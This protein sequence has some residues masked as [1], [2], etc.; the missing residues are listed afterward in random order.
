LELDKTP[1]AALL[2]AA[3]GQGILARQLP[4]HVHYAGVDIAEQLI[5]SAKQRTKRAQTQFKVGDIT[6]ALPFPPGTF[7]HASCILALQN[8]QHGDQAVRQIAQALKPG[9]RCVF[10]LNH[11]CFRI[12]RQSHWAVDEG[13]SLQYRRV[14]RYM[15]ALDIPIQTNPSQGKKSQETWSFHHPLSSY[16]QWLSQAGLSLTAMEEWCSDKQSSG[17]SAKRENRAR[18]EIPLFLA[19]AATKN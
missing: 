6:Q 16:I 13:Q 10:V 12:P 4:K 7:S 2:D 3:C 15:S 18:Q 5:Q 8:I 11:P 9:G 19:L 14:D 17:A 1:H